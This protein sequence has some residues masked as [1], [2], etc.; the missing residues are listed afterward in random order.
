MI[1]IDTGGGVDFSL[2]KSNLVIDGPDDAFAISRVPDD[3]NM[4]ISNSN[5]LVGNSGIG[6]DSVLFFSDKQDNNQHFNFNNTVL[7]GIAFWSLGQ[8]GGEIHIDNSQGCV[9]LVA[10]KINLNNVR[11][12]RCAF[13][14]LTG[15]GLEPV[16][17]PSSIVLL[18]A[19][20]IF[21]LGVRWRKRS[22]R[23]A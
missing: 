1:D 3:A 21:V 16:P 13:G 2:D 11:F 15:L 10:D 4:L 12:N 18:G 9:Q 20:A 8:Q 23:S 7:N 17:E 6:M 14:E 22:K 5:V 19:G